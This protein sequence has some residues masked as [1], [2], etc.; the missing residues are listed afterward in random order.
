MPTKL[1]YDLISKVDNIDL[2]NVI[3]EYK[4]NNTV[5]RTLNIK[6]L[7]E[8]LVVNILEF[9]SKNNPSGDIKLNK[10]SDEDNQKII[11][12]K[13][14]CS[15]TC[16][17]FWDILNYNDNYLDDDKTRPNI[18]IIE[19]TPDGKI[20][21]GADL[22]AVLEDVQ[23]A[24]DTVT[25]EGNQL[26]EVISDVKK[27]TNVGTVVNVTAHLFNLLTKV[28][29]YFDVIVNPDI[30]THYGE[31]IA[32][33][34][35]F[36][37]SCKIV[38]DR[39]KIVKNINHSKLF[40]GKEEEI[41]DF[42]MYLCIISLPI[43]ELCVDRL[44]TDNIQLFVI[45]KEEMSNKIEQYYGTGGLTFVLAAVDKFVETFTKKYEIGKKVRTFG[46]WISEKCCCCCD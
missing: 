15:N 18:E 1:K 6:K 45:T 22:K 34:E 31:T 11:S 28:S 26:Q 43:I 23:L 7:I 46:N 8:N 16:D 25:E 41:I 29:M 39:F 9:S 19:K 4:E 20:V 24:I 38:Y 36:F 32:D 17:I 33:F 35:N 10:Y 5:M 2:R 14:A 13:E 21:I 40:T 37:A 30:E 27:D 44:K 3:D 12:F 42:V